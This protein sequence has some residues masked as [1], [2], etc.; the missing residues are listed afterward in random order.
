M[1]ILIIT[2]FFIRGGTEVQSKREKEILEKQGHQVS[3]LTFDTKFPHNDRLYNKK[4]GFYNIPI[5]E[6]GV[7]RFLRILFTDFVLLKKIRKLIVEINPEIIH[8]NNVTL[9]PLTQYKALKGYKV[10]QS[11]RD[12]RAVCF[13]GTCIYKDK[14]I[15]K[16][17]KYNECYKKCGDFKPGTLLR[18][19]RLQTVKKLSKEY[20]YKFFSPSSILT[21]YCNDHGM[22]TVCI[23][24]PFDF[25]RIKDFAKSCDFSNKKYLYFGAIN[26][27]KGI[28]QFIEAF[29]NF[30][31]GKN[32]ELLL[33]GELKY[34]DKDTLENLIKDKDNIKYLGYL[35]YD[36]IL[37]LLQE[38]YCV[39]VPSLWMENYPNT[40][41]EGIA[42]ENLVIGS[43]RG[44]I[45]ELIRDNGITFDILKEDTI[46]NA[47]EQSY[48]M[49]LQE[50]H[51]R[52]NKAKSEALVNNH[53]DNFYKKIIKEFK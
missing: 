32:I 11:I 22:N 4:N 30:S 19:Y 47:L 8:V 51:A 34:A 40:V 7:S 50:Y 27:D 24:N 12:F 21:E 10:F 44:G 41:L 1:R 13:K 5:H 9:A 26:E 53:V 45:P 35:K 20:V 3:L 36:N 43:N 46:I 37:K 33:A 25:S 17:Y 15:C 49:D 23:N 6:G 28:F 2:D 31:K 16:G 29:N 52:V 48:N 18:M 39:V 42:T 14:G 38:T